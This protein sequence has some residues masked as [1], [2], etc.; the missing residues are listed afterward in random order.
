MVGLDV[1]FFNL[2]DSTIFISKVPRMIKFFNWCKSVY[3]TEFPLSI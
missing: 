3:S 2:N 1:F